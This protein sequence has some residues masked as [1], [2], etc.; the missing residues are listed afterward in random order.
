MLDNRSLSFRMSFFILSSLAILFAAMF[1]YYY[2]SS[3]ES[4][5][6]DIKKQAELIAKTHILEIE[7]KM[8]LV[9][10][11]VQIL[12]D[13]VTSQNLKPSAI[14]QFLENTVKNSPFLYGSNIS[15]EPKIVDSTTGYFGPYYYRGNGNNELK[16]LELA[17]SS[18]K[19]WT[20]DWYLNAKNSEQ[21]KWTE[22][23]FD[24]A[25]GNTYMTTFTK[26]VFIESEVDNER[27][28]IFE[29][30]KGDKMNTT[31]QLY[32]STIFKI[33]NNRNENYSL[34]IIGT[35]KSLN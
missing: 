27:Q 12:A 23:F 35:E 8:F 20:W 33:F 24:S 5:K 34:P 3:R 21:S 15:L 25:G 22:P 28:V 31:K 26:P 13:Y 1:S 9:E 18:Y 32:E 6:K 17:D 7:Q 2:I 19:F 30:M 14:K 29:E 10:R 16:Y 11:N 4:V